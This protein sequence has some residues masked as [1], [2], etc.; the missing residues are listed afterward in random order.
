MIVSRLALA[1]AAA[2]ALAGPAAAQFHLQSHRFDGATVTG[3]EPGILSQQLPDAT[4]AEVRAAMVWNMRA[5]LNVAALQCQFE[6]TL[7][8]V[9]NYNA[10]LKDHDAEFDGSQRI[11]TKYFARTNK[12][13]GAGQKALDQFGTRTY[14]SFV[15]VG[16]QLGFCQTAAAIGR[17]AVFQPRGQFGAFAA[18]RLRQVRNSLFGSWGDEVR[19]GFVHVADGTALPRFDPVC[20]DKKGLWVAKKCGALVWPPVPV[21]TAA[22]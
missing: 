2:F 1:A 7:L 14:S 11:L 13:A 12:A 22:N 6:P 18:D 8:T 17:D 20:W 10:V 5:A 4:P 15:T 9:P 16:G 19:P 3:G 21:A